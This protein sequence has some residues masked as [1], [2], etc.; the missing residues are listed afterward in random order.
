MAAKCKVQAYLPAG[1]KAL[2]N[3]LGTAPGIMAEAEGKLV[4]AL[5]GVPSEMRQ[6]FEESVF[7]ELRRL[8][9]GQAV[10]IRKLKCFGAGESH[11]AELLGDMMQRGRNPLT[12]C[13]AKHG[14][15]TLTV[16]ATAEDKDKAT[17]MAEKHKKFLR[18]ILG[19]LVYGTGEQTLAEVV[20]EKLAAR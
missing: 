1:T 9:S 19:E 12:N 6:M 8:G 11:I 3:N 14:V 5:P 13:T 10:V 2:A 7:P 4:I 20:G 15:I 18:K 17:Q 16:T